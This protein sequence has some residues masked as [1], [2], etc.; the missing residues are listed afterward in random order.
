MRWREEPGGPVL[1]GPITG[2]L[3]ARV[4]WTGSLWRGTVWGAIGSSSLTCLALR[5][6]MDWCEGELRA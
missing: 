1:R 3:V 2:V 6:A 5:D 4:N